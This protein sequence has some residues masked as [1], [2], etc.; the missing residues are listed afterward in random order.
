MRY[1]SSAAPSPTPSSR[2]PAPPP[3]PCGRPR[4]R[5]TPSH[6]VAPGG[7]QVKLWE[8]PTPYELQKQLE[9]VADKLPDIY[10]SGTTL[11]IWLERESA[12]PLPPPP[13]EEGAFMEMGP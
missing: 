9:V 5:T 6:R 10:T 12:P 4:G 3:Q 8:R 7:E 1:T 2:R 11:N 13:S